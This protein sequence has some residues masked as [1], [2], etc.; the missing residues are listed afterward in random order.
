M[1][2]ATLSEVT[3]ALGDERVS[4]IGTVLVRGA[5]DLDSRDQTPISSG[6]VDSDLVL[7]VVW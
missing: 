1:L 6:V 7:V 5:D 4:M 3:R 2:T